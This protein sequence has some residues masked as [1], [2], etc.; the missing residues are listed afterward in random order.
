MF[1]LFCSVD[2]R[3]RRTLRADDRS[4]PDFGRSLPRTALR[5][6]VCAAAFAALWIVPR[7]AE[8]GR[9]E[10]AAARGL[11]LAKKGDCVA[12]TPLLEEAELARHRPSTAS[13]L[14]GC[15]VSLGDLLRAAELYHAIADEEPQRGWTVADRRAAKDAKKKADD[16]DARIPT[17]T[18]S[19]PEAYENLDVLINGK[20]WSDPLEPKKV[21]PDTTVEI[22]AQAKDTEVYTTKI[23]LAEGERLVLELRLVRKSKSKQKP[24]GPAAT[25]ADRPSTWLGARFRGFLMPKFMVNTA[26][27]SGATLFAPGAGLTVATKAGEA[28][29]V[30]SA[31]YANYRVPE[32]PIKPVGKPDTEYEI[33]ESDLQALFAT[34]DI[35]WSKELDDKGNW[36][37]RL[38]LGIGVGWF[39]YGNL[40]RTQAYPTTQSGNDPYLY[41]KCRGPNNPF[42]SFRYCNQL[43]ADADHYPGYT[44]PSWIEGGYLPTV[45][46]FLAFPELGLSWT[47]APNVALDL[48]VAA[49][50]SGI[51][52]GLGFRYGL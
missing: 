45:F 52:M 12:A 48:E 32:M 9:P 10:W 35:L 28:M 18:L 50:V 47:P 14:A 34:M 22:E 23:V 24:P 5:V 19:I 31:A 11:A 20:S 51:M 21:A 37:A 2:S 13:A 44:E 39:F 38:G 8:A 30:F 43:D 1:A 27:D 17:I 16:V 15:Y 4:S 26:F 33:V 29:L 46:P 40:Y 42:G 3:A 6:A 36:S 7:R 41:A 25:R 49:T